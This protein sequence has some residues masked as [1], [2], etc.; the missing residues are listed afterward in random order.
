MI[1][2]VQAMCDKFEP[3]DIADEIAWDRAV[4]ESDRNMRLVMPIVAKVKQE[5]KR[6]NWQGSVPCPTGCGRTL[7][8]SHAAINGHVWGND[9]CR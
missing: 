6:M 5:H 7:R 1:D 9:L 3:S 4:E 2:G 8:L